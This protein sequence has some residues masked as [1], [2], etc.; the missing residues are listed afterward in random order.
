[1]GDGRLQLAKAPEG[2]YD[3]LFMDAFTSDAVPVHLITREAIELYK[4]KLAPDGIL[5]INI[6]NRYIEFR[7]VLGNLAKATGLVAMV[8][9]DRGDPPADRYGSHWVVLARDHKAFGTLT[10]A[11]REDGDNPG[12]PWFVELPPDP[13]SGVGVWSDDFSNILRVLRW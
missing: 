1:M 6:A 11:T 8:A 7:P 12:K 9:E 3:V 2:G 10:E 5:V 4:T 13:D